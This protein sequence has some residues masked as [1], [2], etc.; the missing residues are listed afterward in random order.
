MKTGV[1]FALMSFCLFMSSCG[2]SKSE[3]NRADYSNQLMEMIHMSQDDFNDLESALESGDYGKAEQAWV[4]WVAYLDKTLNEVSEMGDFKG[5]S[6]LK[7]IS[8]KRLTNFKDA[9]QDY[10]KLIS[11]HMATNNEEV[12][13]S[14]IET[15]ILNSIQNKMNGLDYEL[16]EVLF[17]FRSSL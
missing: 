4:A 13:D 16:N 5:D 10:E 3:N 6:S 15:E 11:L 9:A 14:N 7:D 2:G 17:N 8:I 12:L 1:L